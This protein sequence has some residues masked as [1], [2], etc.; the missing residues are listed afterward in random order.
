MA[1]GGVGE[2]GAGAVSA[3]NEVAGTE[4]LL[5]PRKRA[6]GQFTK[7]FTNRCR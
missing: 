1:A 2:V 5:L 7:L 3:L 6:A 4:L